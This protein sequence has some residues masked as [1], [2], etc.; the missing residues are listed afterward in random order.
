MYKVGKPIMTANGVV[1]NIECSPYVVQSHNIQ[2][3]FSSELH[4]KKFMEKTKSYSEEVAESLSRRFK[5]NV[6]F[7]ILAELALYKKIETRGFVVKYY[8]PIKCEVVEV[9]ENNI[10]LD[11]LGR[12]RKI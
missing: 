3:F 1:K 10:R 6:N 12:I 11:G 4:L 2:Y 9:C 5:V 7:D 8:D